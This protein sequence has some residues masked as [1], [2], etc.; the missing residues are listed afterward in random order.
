MAHKGEIPQNNSELQTKYEPRHNQPGKKSQVS[1][2]ITVFQLKPS[3]TLSN[4]N[5][6]FHLKKPK[7]IYI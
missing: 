1:M 2:T 5:N 6:I 4:I 7:F 3:F